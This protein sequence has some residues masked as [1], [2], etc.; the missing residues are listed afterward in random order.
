MND[1]CLS[2]V[3]VLN[4]HRN[5]KGE[6][7]SQ[8][9]RG[10]CLRFVLSG[11]HL[12]DSLDAF[13]GSCFGAWVHTSPG[14]KLHKLLAYSCLLLQDGGGGKSSQEI[15]DDLAKDI[16]SKIPPDFNLES[17]KVWMDISH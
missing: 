1:C 5:T 10:V 8:V 4:P 15:I 2:F 11:H 13:V 12:V 16:V 7:A 17:V 14:I 6:V 9:V 3:A